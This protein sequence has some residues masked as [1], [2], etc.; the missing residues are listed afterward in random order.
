M[1]NAAAASLVLTRAAEEKE[2]ED[3]GPFWI[4]DVYVTG[5]LRPPGI[6]VYDWSNF[7]LRMHAHYTRAVLQGRFFSPELM[8]ASDL[9]PD[10]IRT[11]FRKFRES[12]DKG[13]AEA[14]IYGDPRA[15]E[16]LQPRMVAGGEGTHRG[17][18]K[19][20]EL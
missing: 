5:M 16:L 12:R 10:E 18:R 7:N 8:V 1:T 17:R 15:V 14:A 13:W 11:L 19:R 3:R 20:E 4:D 6:P 2:K 9:R